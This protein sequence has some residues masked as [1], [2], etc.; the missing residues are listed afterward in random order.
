MTDRCVL[1]EL[2]GPRSPHQPSRALF[3]A[4][5]RLWTPLPCPLRRAL[6]RPPWREVLPPRRPI[7]SVLP[8]SLEP[9]ERWPLLVW[10]GCGGGEGRR[11]H[12]LCRG[13]DSPGLG[14]PSLQAGLPS[15]S[16]PAGGC[17]WRAFPELPYL[18]LAFEQDDGRLEPSLW[19]VP[20]LSRLWV[21][22]LSGGQWVA[23]LPPHLPPEPSQDWRPPFGAGPSAPLPLTARILSACV[24]AAAQSF[25]SLRLRKMPRPARRTG[26]ALLP[27]QRT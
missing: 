8:R 14:A 10:G 4:L 18:L 20:G 21:G 2:V 7:C 27:V 16:P 25:L 3:A 23:V 5:R 17:I 12:C 9:A 22:R 13:V 6:G 11:S 26:L 1:R 15:L 24:C 19:Q